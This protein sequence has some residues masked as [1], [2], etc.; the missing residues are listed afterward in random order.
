MKDP[1]CLPKLAVLMT[2]P[3]PYKSALWSCLHQKHQ[4]DLEVLYASDEG[5]K[6][7]KD[8]HFGRMIQW[9]GPLMDGYPWRVIGHRDWKWLNWRAQYVVLGIRRELQKGGF[10]HVLLPGKEYLYYQQGFCAARR[11][12]LPVLYRAESHP[13]KGNRFLEQLARLNRKLLYKRIE[14]FLCVGRNQF[15]EYGGYGISR[16][17][18]FFSPYSVDQAYFDERQAI[19]AGQRETLRCR[20]G[21]M[22]NSFVVG[23]SG[24]LYDRKNPLE[25]VEAVGRLRREGANVSLL[26]VGEGPLRAACE[27]RAAQVAAGAAAFPGFLNQSELTQAYLAMDMFVMPSRWETWGLV[28]NEAMLH[29]L[30]VMGTKTSHSVN[31]LIEDGVNGYRY[32]SGD[33]DALCAGIRRI[34]EC[35]GRGEPFGEQSRKR[36][37]EYSVEQAAEGVV[38]AI[39]GTGGRI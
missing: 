39:R 4:L 28:L 18:M 13:E 8:P 34:K 1:T 2:V 32:Q 6:A 23:F 20:Y 33:Q 37:E 22:P 5:V 15:H 24:R 17:R 25:L 31:E 19:L 38:Q 30:P 11:L 21:I 14:A 35:V 26:M 7:Y 3:A 9:D 27:A 36:V 10:T 29:R 12:G 16:D